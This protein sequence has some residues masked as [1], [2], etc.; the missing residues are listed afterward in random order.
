M[1]LVGA[2]RLGGAVDDSAEHFRVS[3]AG[4]ALTAPPDVAASGDE[5]KGD[6]DSIYG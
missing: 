4:L 6:Q 3:G 1:L 2:D 5:P